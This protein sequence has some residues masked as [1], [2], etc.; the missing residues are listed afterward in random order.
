MIGL[1]TNVLVRYMMQ[2]DPEQSPLS[3]RLVESLSVE[4]PGFVALVSVVELGWM[5]D[6]AYALDRHQIADAFEAL[7]VAG[8]KRA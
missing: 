3:T 5:L 6:A 7:L 8:R 1:D 4:S 2:D